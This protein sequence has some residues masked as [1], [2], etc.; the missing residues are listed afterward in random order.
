[1]VCEIMITAVE[2]AANMTGTFILF[3]RKRDGTRLE[4]LRLLLSGLH[5]HHHHHDHHHD[6]HHHHHHEHIKSFHNQVFSWF[7]LF[8]TTGER[9]AS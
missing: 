3:P 4:R 1:M 9:R 5:H 8:F 7:Q 6:H 2:Q